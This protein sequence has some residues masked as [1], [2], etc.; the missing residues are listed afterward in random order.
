MLSSLVTHLSAYNGYIADINLARNPLSQSVIFCPAVRVLD[1]YNDS[2]CSLTADPD[3]IDHG[4]S[5]EL[6]SEFVRYYD[7]FTPSFEHSPL[8]KKAILNKS[9]DLE[10]VQDLTSP[11][12]DDSPDSL[13]WVLVMS[14]TDLPRLPRANDF[15]LLY[16][17]PNNSSDGFPSPEIYTV[18]VVK[19][20]SRDAQSIIKVSIY[21]E[22]NSKVISSFPQVIIPHRLPS[23]SYHIYSFHANLYLD[24]EP[25]DSSIINPSPGSILT[26]GEWSYVFS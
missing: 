8:L 4:Y 23:G 22:R 9:A 20:L 13:P 7:P 3:R 1:Q 19:P 17:D 25:L 26:S 2:Y 15:F 11:L 14:T 10:F 21:P 6:T 5:D 24:G 18:S 12:A 16:S